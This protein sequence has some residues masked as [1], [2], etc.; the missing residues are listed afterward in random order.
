VVKKDGREDVDENGTE[1]ADGDGDDT[2]DPSFVSVGSGGSES[3]SFK[4]TNE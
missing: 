3:N 1:D 2:E 4:G